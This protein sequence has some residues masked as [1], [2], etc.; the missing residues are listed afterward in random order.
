LHGRRR[1]RA[2]GGSKATGLAR[3]Q[4]QREAAYRV[5]GV[6]PGSDPTSV[7]QAFRRLAAVHH[8]DRHPGAT[9]EELRSLVQRFT[10][11]T[12]AYQA[13]AGN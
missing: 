2:D 10:R 5:L 13:V 6:E 3:D 1:A 8:P 9:A 4:L 12:A 7:R 11:I